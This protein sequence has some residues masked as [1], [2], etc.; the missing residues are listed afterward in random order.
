MHVIS[1]K[2]NDFLVGQGFVF[3][4]FVN[5]F[6][7]IKKPE[8]GGEIHGI[9]LKNL[10]NSNCWE[11]QCVGIGPFIAPIS[12]PLSNGDKISTDANGNFKKALPIDKAVGSVV[13]SKNGKTYSI[14]HN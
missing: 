6:W 14:I 11:V 3:D 2:S 7:K 1:N 4:D 8:N 9:I 10:N 12:H 5:G 13:C